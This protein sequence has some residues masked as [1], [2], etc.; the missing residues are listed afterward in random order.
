M[1]NIRKRHVKYFPLKSAPPALLFDN[2][3]DGFSRTRLVNVKPIADDPSE[4]SVAPRVK[5]EYKFT[6]DFCL[7]EF[8]L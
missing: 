4:I 2:E 1:E 8:R 6:N 5:F 7:I 3:I